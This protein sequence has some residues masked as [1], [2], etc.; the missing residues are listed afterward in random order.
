[1]SCL[2]KIQLQ[3]A[4]RV[5]EAEADSSAVEMVSEEEAAEAY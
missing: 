5:T 1:M 2:P 4:F 3:A